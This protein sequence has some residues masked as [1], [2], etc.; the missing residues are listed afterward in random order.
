[1]ASSANIRFTTIPGGVDRLL[2]T[3]TGPYAQYLTRTGNRVVNA[4]K[5]RANVDTGLMRS[6]IEFRLESEGGHLV[7]IV[8]ANTNYS[9]YV[10]DGNGSYPGNPFLTDALRDVLG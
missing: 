10:H 8:A 1:M 5:A 3:T 9:R 7:G 4:A 2:H 6:R